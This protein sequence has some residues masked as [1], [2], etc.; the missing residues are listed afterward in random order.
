MLSQLLEL[1]V[2]SGAESFLRRATRAYALSLL[3]LHASAAASASRTAGP[4]PCNHYFRTS[5]RRRACGQT[6]RRRAP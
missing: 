3:S 4:P 5:A 2:R 1:P 6:A